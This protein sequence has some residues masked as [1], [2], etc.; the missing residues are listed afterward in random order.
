MARNVEEDE[1]DLVVNIHLR[2]GAGRKQ[3]YAISPYIYST[4]ADQ[5]YSICLLHEKITNC[6]N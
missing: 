3:V 5:I 4:H 2:V 1:K 6:E